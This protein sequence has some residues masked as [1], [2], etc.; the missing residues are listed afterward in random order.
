MEKHTV[1]FL[2]TG[3]SA[4]SQIAEAFLREI[5]GDRF[6]SHSAG[7]EPKEINPLTIRVMN[8]IGIS[9]DGQE[10]KPLSNYLA[11]RHVHHVITVC[12]DAESKCPQVW[13][14]GAEILH[15]PFDDPAA[16]EGTEEE[17]LVVFRRVRD[18]VREKISTW[19]ESH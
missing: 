18:E 1:L 19:V 7:L 4:R 17:K 9:L 15:W 5:A 8:E 3:N 16:A 10:S 13:P 14:F 12:A 6:E 2:C 11:K